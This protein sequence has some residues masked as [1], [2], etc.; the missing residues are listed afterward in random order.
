MNSQVIRIQYDPGA[1][2]FEGSNKLDPKITGSA[3]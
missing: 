3:S 1:S 2:G